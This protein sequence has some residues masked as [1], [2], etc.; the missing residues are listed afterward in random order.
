L[1]KLRFTNVS[2]MVL[3]FYFAAQ[4][5]EK[6]TDSLDLRCLRTRKLLSVKI[7]DQN[8]SALALHKTDFR[9]H[10]LTAGRTTRRSLLARRGDGTYESPPPSGPSEE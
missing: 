2:R 8:L 9:L 6:E 3:L 5:A 1:A 4:L 7:I 10:R